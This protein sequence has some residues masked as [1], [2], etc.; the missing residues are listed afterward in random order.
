MPL[1]DI[2][3]TPFLIS[4]GITL[5]LVGIIVIFI[6]QRFQE[7]NHKISSMFGLVSSMAEEMN[8]MRGK[9]QSVTFTSMP[10]SQGGGVG[11]GGGV[12]LTSASDKLIDV[13]DGEEDSGEDSDED[14]CEDSDSDSDSEKTSEDRSE[15]LTRGKSRVKLG[16]E[17]SEGCDMCEE[18]NRLASR[19]IAKLLTKLGSTCP[20]VIEQEIKRQF[21][22]FS[23]DIISVIGGD[24]NE[25]DDDRFNR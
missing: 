16:G 4:L 6:M 19:H 7:Q 11:T 2:I 22:F 23:N 13:S 1:S 9:L 20:P 21:R 8:Y 10:S 14:S 3:T 12:V 24:S 18:I 15:Y 5:L 25:Q 17:M